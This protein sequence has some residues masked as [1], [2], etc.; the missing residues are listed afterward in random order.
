MKKVILTRRYNDEAIERLRREFQLL[1]AADEG[2]DLASFLR[3]HADAEG[4]ISFLSDPVD[5]AMIG[6]LPKLKIIANYAVGY[7]NIDIGYALEKNV[8]IT[9]TPDVLTRAMAMMTVQAVR[10]TLNGKKPQH[11]IPE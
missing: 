5:R 4:L 6:G 2:A 8:L 7:N 9:H 11:L 10:Q 1:I 3:R